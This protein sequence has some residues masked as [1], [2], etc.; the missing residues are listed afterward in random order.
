MLNFMLPNYFS[1]ILKDLQYSRM[2]CKYRNVTKEALYSDLI[3]L[4]E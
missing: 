2:R 1:L 3:I 4:M